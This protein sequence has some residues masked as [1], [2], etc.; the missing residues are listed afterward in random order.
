M[1]SIRGD[2]KAMPLA[3]AG[4]NPA[5]VQCWKQPGSGRGLPRKLLL[6]F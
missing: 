3:I 2:M 6:H 1:R 5:P 4:A